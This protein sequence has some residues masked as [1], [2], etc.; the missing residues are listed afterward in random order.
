MPIRPIDI[1]KSQE[2]SQLKH[3]ESHRSQQEQ[4]QIGK[5]FQS[6]INSESS[7][8]NQATKSENKEFRYDAKEKG[9]N[10]YSGSQGRK[11][12]KKEEKHKDSKEPEKSGGIDILI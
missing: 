9:Q 7:R 6:M 4:V 12:E 3:L 5:S 2:V 8:P 11:Q 1:M 10:S